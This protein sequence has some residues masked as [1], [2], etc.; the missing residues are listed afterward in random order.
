MNKI[1]DNAQLK[2]KGQIFEVY[3]WEQKLY[4]GSTDIFERLKRTDTVIIYPV[5]EDKQS[6]SY[7]EGKK[8]ILTDQEQPER[9]PFITGAA[10]RVEE[11]ESP[12][13]CAKRELLEETGYEASEWVLLDQINPINKIVWTIHVYIAKGCKKVAEINPDPGEKIKV[14]LVDFEEFLNLDSEEKFHD[15][16]MIIR[17]L[18]AK[19]DPNEMEKFKK[20]FFE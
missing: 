15:R 17:I 14:R 7:G 9:E 13:E 1:P 16:E 2:F 4:D 3:Q 19:A 10:G 18:K 6:F 11:G 5:T 12:L 20:A 8:I